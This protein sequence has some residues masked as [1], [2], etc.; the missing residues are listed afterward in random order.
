LR[1]IGGQIGY[2]PGKYYAPVATVGDVLDDA[3][4]R[5]TRRGSTRDVPEAVRAIFPDP[6]QVWEDGDLPPTAVSSRSWDGSDAGVQELRLNM[7]PYPVQAQRIAQI[8]ARQHAAEERLS[9]MLPPSAID[10]IV[11]ARVNVTFPSDDVR[12]GIWI[13]E[14]INPHVWMTEE[15]GVQFRCAADLRRDAADIW[16]WDPDDQVDRYSEPVP[17]LSLALEPPTNLSASLSDFLLTVSFE[18]AVNGAFYE[19]QF[20][21]TADEIWTP[22]PD[23]SSDLQISGV[24]SANATVPDDSADYDVRVRTRNGSRA[25]DWANAATS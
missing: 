10:L 11:G 2:L 9:A 18:V 3:P 14:N 7:V 21:N 5:Y 1:Q 6:D 8:V 12:N 22:L 20:K 4:V 25:S 15:G 16:A 23:L 19:W 24:I 17:D 13:I